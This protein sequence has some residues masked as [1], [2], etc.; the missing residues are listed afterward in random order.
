MM[1]V[2]SLLTAVEERHRQK[3]SSLQCL[4]L[5]A[6]KVNHFFPQL[7]SV[8]PVI[9]VINISAQVNCARQGPYRLATQKMLFLNLQNRIM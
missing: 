7:H 3:I 6:C 2:P 8:R 5:D 1:S 9:T 4:R